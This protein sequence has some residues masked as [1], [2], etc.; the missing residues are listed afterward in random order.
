ME[1]TVQYELQKNIKR[2]GHIDLPG[3]GQIVVD[4]NYAYVGHMKPPYGTTILDV[5]DPKRPKILSMIELPD[6][7]SH[8]HK[9]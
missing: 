4:G 5:A 9:V 1:Q 8:T 3:G 2:V 7:Y 6:F